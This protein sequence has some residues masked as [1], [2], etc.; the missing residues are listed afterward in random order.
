MHIFA[1]LYQIDWHMG[2]G[3]SMKRR[4]VLRPWRVRDIEN[5][6]FLRREPLP[7]QDQVHEKVCNEQPINLEGLTLEDWKRLSF[8]KNMD[9]VVVRLPISR[10]W[11]R[12]PQHAAHL[13]FVTRTDDDDLRALVPAGCGSIG[14]SRTPP[15]S[16]STKYS[17]AESISARLRL[18]HA[19][20]EDC[21]ETRAFP[22]VGFVKWLWSLPSS[23]WRKS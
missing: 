5:K 7:S 22:F 23:E 1:I 19:K 20:G 10:S 9:D 13:S 11:R 16:P 17:G 15:P 8:R 21:E 6:N 18:D 3:K 2:P 14:S 12:A 4:P